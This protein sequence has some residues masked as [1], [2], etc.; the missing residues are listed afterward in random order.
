MTTTSASTLEL[1]T[2]AELV[3]RA[4]E[5]K[6]LLAGNAAQGETDRRVVEEHPGP[7]RRG[8]VQDLGAQAVRRIRDVDAHHARR[9][10]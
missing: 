5:L 10:R 6:P 8:P 3:A 1:P 7:Y 2:S 4:R 9:V